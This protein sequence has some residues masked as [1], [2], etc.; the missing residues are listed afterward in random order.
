[1]TYYHV[2]R[3]WTGGDDLLSLADQ[4]GE[5]E[6][7]RQFCEQWPDAC[8]IADIHVYYIH[9]FDTE[10]DAR[11]MARDL[12]GRVLAIDGEFIDVSIDTSEPNHPHHVTRGPIPETDIS[13]LT[14]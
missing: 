8:G 4:L 9:L 2:T 10:E 6:A 1:M 3:T 5:E 12:G 11:E 7:V 14:A 13:E